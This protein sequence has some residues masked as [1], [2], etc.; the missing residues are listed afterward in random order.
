MKYNRRYKNL[1]TTDLSLVDRRNPAD[2]YVDGDGDDTNDPEDST[3]CCAVVAE[4]DGEDDA[5]EISRC[6][7]D[8]GDDPVL[9][10]VSELR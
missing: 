8:A 4:D 6:A 10:A 7:D 2:A 3:V 5:T 9:M 1:T